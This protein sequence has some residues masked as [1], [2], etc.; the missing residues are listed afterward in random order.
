MKV[1]ILNQKLNN[2]NPTI[3]GFYANLKHAKSSLSKIRRHVRKKWKKET[4]EIL[5]PH[6]G[7]NITSI[8]IPITKKGI[9][10][11]LNILLNYE[12]LQRENNS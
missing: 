2:L 8:E 1:Y 3:V 11:S 5:Y 9:I 6:D 4:G 7:L 10:N 12:I